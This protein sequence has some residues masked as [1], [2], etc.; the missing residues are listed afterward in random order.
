MSA[1]KMYMVAQICVWENHHAGT[2]CVTNPIRKLHLKKSANGPDEISVYDSDVK[3]PSKYIEP[4]K[5]LF[6]I[7]H[8][9]STDQRNGG[10]SVVL[11]VGFR[12][13]KNAYC[14]Y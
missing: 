2:T 9:T 5:V 3:C 12:G 13:T 6:H 11:D 4:I 7:P 10:D 14:V 8:H 1:S